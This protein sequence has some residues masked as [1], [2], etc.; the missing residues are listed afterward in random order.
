MPDTNTRQAIL[1]AMLSQLET[2]NFPVGAKITYWDVFE[3]DYNGAATITVRD[4]EEEMSK[5]NQ[6]YNNVLGVEVESVAYTT[7]ANKLTDSCAM[8]EALKTALL[9]EDWLPV[10]AYVRPLSNTKA[11]AEGGKIGISVVLNLE[12]EY[13]QIA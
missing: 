11:I 10:P 3:Q 6:F 4:E 5:S 1:E 7:S 13:R 9:L 2:V 12:I 8:L